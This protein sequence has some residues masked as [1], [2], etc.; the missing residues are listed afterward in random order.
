VSAAPSLALPA[1]ARATADPGLLAPFARTVTRHLT[2]VL[3]A[4]R[5]ELASWRAAAAAIPD[6]KLRAVALASLQKRGNIEGAALFAGLAPAA[7]RA[8]AIRALVAYQTAYNYLDALADQPGSDPQAGNLCL[9]EALVRPFLPAGPP[10]DY[11][12]L[13]VH[14]D[15]GGYLA[16]CVQ[17]CRDAFLSLP[18]HRAVTSAAL[19]AAQ[20]IRRFQSLNLAHRHGGH[21]A[22]RSWAGAV[23][24]DHGLEWWETAAAAGSSLAVH[25]LIAA[26]AG[27]STTGADVAVIDDAYFP[28]AGAL[29]SLLDSL[30]D[31]R[32]DALGDQ[33]ALIDYYPSTAVAAQRLTFLAAGAVGRLARA[34]AAHRAI[35]TAMCSY[36]LTAPECD[37]DEAHRATIALR[38]TLGVPLT[39]ALALFR[40][41]RA[42]A[43]IARDSYV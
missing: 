23:T 27:P 37:R 22:L 19:S 17:V 15:D 10:P 43:D 7:S 26:A 40:A 16:G 3:P 5:R 42:A 35:L 12:A 20:R 41:R 18:R 9:H 28:W 33:Q 14:A 32:E 24:P 4:A 36:Y 34:P 11:Y 13:S 6:P 21:A 2:R 29:H 25:A 1:A 39:V 38:G 30:V 8:R 31:R